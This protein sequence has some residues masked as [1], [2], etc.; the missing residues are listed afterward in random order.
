MNITELTLDHFKGISETLELSQLNVL[1]GPNG[2]GKSG[3][4]QAIQ[5]AVMGNTQFGYTADAVAHLAGP[6]G[7]SVR[8]ML[9]AGGFEWKRAL[10]I[11][12][13][14]DTKS[15]WLDIPGTQVRGVRE[16]EPI[17]QGKVGAFA[18]MF[19]LHSF[20][21]LSADKRR[22]FVLELCARGTGETVDQEDMRA[23]LVMEIGKALLG[24]GTVDTLGTAEAVLAR[25]DEFT[26][27]HVKTH[28]ATVAGAMRSDMTTSLMRAAETAKELISAHRAAK[29]QAAAAI[30]K[31]SQQK[32]AIPT[33]AGTLTE[34][35]AELA[36]TREQREEIVKQLANQEGRASAI[37]NSVTHLEEAQAARD[38]A[39]GS[40]ADIQAQPLRSIDAAVALR[41]EAATIQK[42]LDAIV[43]EDIDALKKAVETATEHHKA[44][45][46]ARATLMAK[47]TNVGVRVQ[48][49][50][51]QIQDHENSPAL[52]T[53]HLVEEVRAAFQEMCDAND[54]SLVAVEQY[55]VAAESLYEHVASMAD[56]KRGK[57]LNKSYVLAQD[58]EAEVKQEVTAAG[59]QINLAVDA[60]DAAQLALETARESRQ[61]A[62]ATCARMMAEIA[63]KEREAQDIETTH[64]MHADMRTRATASLEEREAALITAQRE[65]ETLRGEEGHIPTDQLETQRTAL[66]N[67]IA[68]TETAIS[69][70]TEYGAIDTQLQEA[71]LSSE[72]EQ[73]AWDVAKKMADA[74]RTLRETMMAKLIAPL[75][76]HMKKFLSVAAPEH[77]PYCDLET[78]TGK[79]AFTL[80][81]CPPDAPQRT[82][83]AMSGGEKVLFGAALAYALI[84]LADPP[85][86]LLML[87]V[88]EVDVEHLNALM[89]AIEH[90][91]DD[92]GNAF[93]STHSVVA[94]EDRAWGVHHRALSAVPA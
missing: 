6:A 1:L 65:L 15:S 68:L 17:L 23:R 94:M 64:A 48:S 50:E 86:R 29:D 45:D 39:A 36:A 34:L 55:A 35:E 7:C 79:P 8:V 53:L 46:S 92:L 4:L 63:T 30:A 57:E 80:G 56:P 60:V 78:T 76:L 11:D 40:L 73:L 74:V 28:A 38:R 18:P 32:A 81:W 62:S 3:I 22:S 59:M 87:E 67:Q 47:Y 88:G 85:L 93:I 19:D 69:Q 21:A 89:D 14:K 84:M 51:Q 66:E 27:K 52:Q 61:E 83:D 72:S 91:S 41:E 82:Y 13:H 9:D 24:P 44:C 10:N 77:E 37:A 43:L 33:V 54:G 12:R 58:E 49:L 75:M 2:S 20:L 25:L 5:Y 31:L 42:E 16:A 71:I 90:V 26:A 70:R